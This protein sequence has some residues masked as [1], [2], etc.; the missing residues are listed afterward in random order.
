MVTVTRPGTGSPGQT[1]AATGSNDPGRIQDY[2]DRGL[3][4]L[5][6]HTQQVND[7]RKEGEYTVVE[8]G[9]GVWL[10]DIKGQRYID[11]MSGLWVVAA[12]HGRSELAEVA[13]KQM[14]S[15]PYANPF[16]YATEPAVDLATR[17]AALTPGSLTRTYFVNTGAEAVETAIRMAKQY[18]YNRGARGRYKIISRMGSYHGMTHGALS[19]NGGAM[20]NRAPFEPLLPGVIQVPNTNG[21]GELNNARTGLDDVFWADFVEETIKFQRPETIAA[22]I[23]EPISTANGCFV[24]ST[25][26]WERIREICDKYEIVLIA[27]EVING[28]GR[29]GRW[30]ACEHFGLEPDIMTMA[31]Q[32]SSG[33]LPIAGVIASDRIASAFEGGK[34]QAFVGGS[35]FGAHPVSCAVS[36]ANIDILERE[37]LVENSRVV[38]DYLGE[39]LEA[40]V[41]RHRIAAGTRGIG[42]M[43]QVMLMR[44]PEAGVRFTPEDDLA[45]RMPAIV[46]AHGLLTR[47]GDTIAIA[48]PLVVSRQEIDDLVD[49]LDG[50]IST[51][52]K[53]IAH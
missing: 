36:L 28:F 10:T 49:R 17:L 38:G 20:I 23:A 33:Y 30:F 14:L 5:W 11:A 15:L 1:A 18:Q 29:T 13:R 40:L 53:Q 43:R 32:I 47:A 52:E 41:S 44:D 12:G 39:Q 16:A 24:P 3:E 21:F 46:R 35:T 50:V 37:N 25:R 51:V 27:D 9:E 2:I 6:I 7:L 34:A 8:S 22:F 42:L 26:Y 48:P 45:G 31:K 19:V 4:H